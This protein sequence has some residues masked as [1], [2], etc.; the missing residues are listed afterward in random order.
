MTEYCNLIG[1]QDSCA[2]HKPITL[3]PDPLSLQSG[4]GNET[5]AVW[6]NGTGSLER[7]GTRPGA[8]RQRSENETSDHVC[9]RTTEYWYSTGNSK[10]CM[11]HQPLPVPCEHILACGIVSFLE[12]LAKRTR[13][14]TRTLSSFSS[15]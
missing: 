9:I 2:V 6:G 11:A 8:L 5:S 14:E 12:V 1:A 15:L 3:F 7:L 4:S 13:D 10:Y